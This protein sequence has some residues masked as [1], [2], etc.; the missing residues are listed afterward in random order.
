MPAPVAHTMG[1]RR[2]RIRP[3]TVTSGNPYLTIAV[4]K[5]PDAY[6]IALNGEADLLG[7]P[8][9]EAALQDAHADDSR[10][11]VV[12]LSELTFID[13]SGLHAL[14]SG[15]ELCRARGQE[16]RVVPGPAN[17]QRLFELAGLNEVLSFAGAPPSGDTPHGVDTA[18]PTET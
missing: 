9:I 4:T 11:V 17:I 2:P 3:V 15:H 18:E 1:R 13:S 5:A 16:L 14:V 10:L 8:E 7:T 6:K 12:D